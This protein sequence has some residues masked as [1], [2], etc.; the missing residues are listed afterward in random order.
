MSVLQADQRIHS[1][2]HVAYNLCNSNDFNLVGC[3][4]KC[5]ALSG[6]G[7]P[8]PKYQRKNHS[9]GI[10]KHPFLYP[11]ISELVLCSEPVLSLLA[12]Q[13]ISPTRVHSE[14]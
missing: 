5:G 11:K 1:S 7:L 4:N 3:V 13:C 2:V 9:K 14:L 6:G 12:L 8:I 10:V